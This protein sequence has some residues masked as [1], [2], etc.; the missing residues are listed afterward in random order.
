MAKSTQL[1]NEKISKID[2]QIAQ[3][4]NRKKL[5]IQKQKAADRRARSNRLY[6][7]HGLIESMMPELIGITDEQFKTFLERAVVNGYGRDI[8]AKIV[9]QGEPS[10]NPVTAEKG[11]NKPAEAAEQTSIPASTKLAGVITT[12]TDPANTKSNATQSS[13][14]KSSNPALAQRNGNNHANGRSNPPQGKLGGGEGRG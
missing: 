9:A 6:R 3:L 14:T 11:A 4:N 2:A 1:A 5:E 8:L 12:T 7:R 13:N 10:S